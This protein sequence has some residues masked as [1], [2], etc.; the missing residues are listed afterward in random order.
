[1]TGLRLG[2]VCVAGFFGMDMWSRVFAGAKD[3]EAAAPSSQRFA[4]AADS[5]SSP[6]FE[7]QQS[8]G[9]ANLY[10][11]TVKG[12]PVGI[13][14]DSQVRRVQTCSLYVLHGCLSAYDLYSQFTM[15]RKTG[16]MHSSRRFTMAI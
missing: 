3:G 2:S 14:M 7:M 16:R 10:T 8:P 5:E 9:A 4:A 13:D 12:A 11:L 6:L 15:H 1:M